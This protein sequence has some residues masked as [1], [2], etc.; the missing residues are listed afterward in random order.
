MLSKRPFVFATGL[1]LI[2]SI[3][4]TTA[5]VALK[6]LQVKNQMVDKQKNILKVLQVT[7][8]GKAYTVD[9]VAEIYSKYVQNKWVNKKGEL[10]DTQTDY[11]VFVYVILGK[12]KAYAIPISGLG[13]WSTLYGY[14][15]VDG[16]GTTVRGITFYEHG[17]T[18]G[19]GAEVEAKWFQ[20]NFLGKKIAK[21]DGTFTSVGIVKGKVK[22]VVGPEDYNH[23]VDGISGATVTSK[24]VDSF[25]KEALQNYEAFSKRLRRKERV[26]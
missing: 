23:Y 16:D 24:G 22:N 5:A 12:V 20:D 21:A 10:L 4:L 3:L 8:P 14:F 25:L 6:P 7:E 17:E 2:C 9:E 15:S 11:P 1:C 26:L 18:P 13:L 19:L